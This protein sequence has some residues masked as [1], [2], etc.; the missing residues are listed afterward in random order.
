M[1]GFWA[2]AVIARGMYGSVSCR[3]DVGPALA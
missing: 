2:T 3:R 1:P